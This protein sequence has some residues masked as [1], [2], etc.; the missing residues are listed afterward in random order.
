M[1]YLL[2]LTLLFPLF[3]QAGWQ[4]GDK[5]TPTQTL[6]IP[7]A[8][9]EQLH[10]YLWLPE[11]YSPNET[12]KAVVLAHGC[13]GAHYKDEPAKW[14]K[15]YVAGKFKVW[16]KLLNEQ[17][18]IVLLVDS[19]TNRDDNGDIGGGVCS[20]SATAL[21]RPVR[22]DPVAVRPADI[23]YGIDYL[24]QHYPVSKVGVMGFSNGG[25]AAL[26][27]ANH[28]NLA[29][30]D[31]APQDGFLDTSLKQ[32]FNL[33]FQANYQADLIVSLYPGCGLNGY[34]PLT[35]NSIQNFDSYTDT[36]L[37]A[38][39]DD[40]ALP[41][42]T[43][44]KCQ[45]LAVEDANRSFESPNMMFKILVDTRH[46]FD[47]KENDEATVAATIQRILALFVSM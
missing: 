30:Q 39:S 33:P 5:K 32:W 28:A 41:S 2:L 6:N 46:Q 10:A 1:K 13:G 38:A 14:T 44:Q 7:T 8:A 26:V 22:I 16:G 18:L 9:G 42:N 43:K 34:S 20:S 4:S 37:Y 29:Q 11:G 27:L 47:Y 35:Q 25:T 17:N 19:F 36:F 45:S 21:E 12:Y 24:K 15:R 23:A 40:A 3:A 31:Q